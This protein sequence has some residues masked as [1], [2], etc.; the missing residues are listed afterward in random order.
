MSKPFSAL[1]VSNEL[2]ES[3]AQLHI[4]KPTA[5]LTITYKEL[6]V[7]PIS[8]HINA[9]DIEHLAMLLKKYAAI[10]YSV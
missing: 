10:L 8:Y 5:R 4:H 7:A 1:G 6:K 3:L 9:D 2:L